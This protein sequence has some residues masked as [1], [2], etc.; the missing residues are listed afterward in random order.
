MRVRLSRPHA[1]LC[2][3]PASRRPTA[4]AAVHGCSGGRTAALVRRLSRRRTPAGSLPTSSRARLWRPRA[5]R[6][7]SR[8]S[9][10]RAPRASPA[11]GRCGPATPSATARPSPAGR[12][13]PTARGPAAPRAEPPSPA[14]TV[15]VGSV[16]GAPVQ[17]LA[18]AATDDHLAALRVPDQHHG[19]LP[20]LRDQPVGQDLQ[21]RHRFPQAHAGQVDDGATDVGCAAGRRNGHR[22]PGPGRTRTVRWLY[23]SDGSTGQPLGPRAGPEAGRLCAGSL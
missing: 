4:R 15:G 5:R 13:A 16:V 11:A 7:G 14:A 17:R 6:R 18:A 10:P 9:R 21:R 8:T 2:H 12:C 22:G 3:A 19:A 23:P 20:Q 1:R